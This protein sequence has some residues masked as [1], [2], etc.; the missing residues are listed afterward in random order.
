MS[1]AILGAGIVGLRTATRLLEQIPTARISILAADLP[2][3][4]NPSPSYSSHWSYAFQSVPEF[5]DEEDEDGQTNALDIKKTESRLRQEIVKDPSCP[6][7]EVVHQ[8]SFC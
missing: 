3:D 2:W 8:V 7:H 1:I 4:T 5:E 6:V